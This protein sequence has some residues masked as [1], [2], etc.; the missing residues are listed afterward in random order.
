M[1]ILKILN[2]SQ[3]DSIVL[4]QLD[5]FS[6][7]PMIIDLTDKEINF[8]SYVYEDYLNDS[9]LHT[10]EILSKKSKL[11]FESLENLSD[12]TK[13]YKFFNFHEIIQENWEKPFKFVIIYF[14]NN[15]LKSPHDINRY[16]QS[17]HDIFIEKLI[18]ITS[19]D[20][21]ISLWA[22]KFRKAILDNFFFETIINIDRN[23]TIQARSFV[24]TNIAIKLDYPVLLVLTKKKT[25]NP[26]KN[27]F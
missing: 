8:K 5:L 1:E 4:I 18:L 20:T 6:L 2:P 23:I 13:T 27:I 17:L 25:R 21:L 22:E 19:G 12:F 7:L 10:I 16:L 14:S 3:N 11:S 15:F 24:E 9:I 26:H